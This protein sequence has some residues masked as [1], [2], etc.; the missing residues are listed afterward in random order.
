MSHFE[1]INAFISAC[2]VWRWRSYS[3]QTN[4]ISSETGLSG[5]QVVGI[6]LV[7]IEDEGGGVKPQ[8]LM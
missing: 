5:H 4:Q 2:A 3:S 6:I 7:M 8:S 1:L